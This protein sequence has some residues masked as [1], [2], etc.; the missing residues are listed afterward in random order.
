MHVVQGHDK[1]K[2]SISYICNMLYI[3]I[4]IKSLFSLETKYT[5]NIALKEKNTM[6]QQYK[7]DINESSIFHYV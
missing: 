5:D 4:E 2:H 1:M 3:F 6:F 7:E